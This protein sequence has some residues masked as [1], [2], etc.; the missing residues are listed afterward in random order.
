[1]TFVNFIIMKKFDFCLILTC[2]INPINM[3][4]L[5]RYD[6][7]VRLND[8]KKSTLTIHFDPSKREM[9]FDV[10]IAKLHYFLDSYLEKPS[11]KAVYHFKTY[12]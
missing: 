6:P 3:P 8:Y 7:Q 12:R 2:T 1:M 11:Q 9:S 10:F 5:V 4:D